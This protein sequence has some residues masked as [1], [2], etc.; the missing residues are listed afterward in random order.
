MTVPE[1]AILGDHARPSPSANSAMC[2]SVVH[3]A[4]EACFWR[5]A[6]SVA[7]GRGVGG[8]GAPHGDAGT[9]EDGQVQLPHPSGPFDPQLLGSANVR[10]HL[11]LHY[12]GDGAEVGEGLVDPAGHVGVAEVRDEVA[13]RAEGGY[14]RPGGPGRSLLGSPSRRRAS[15]PT[16][17][18]IASSTLGRSTP[19]TRLIAWLSSGTVRQIGCK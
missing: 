17:N 18:A 2:T 19:V 12:T 9:G 15:G 6:R 5:R 1:V 7:A 14:T 13:R 4:A 16:P 8:L 11:R 3:A 10:P